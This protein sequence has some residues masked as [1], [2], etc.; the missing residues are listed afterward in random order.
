MK[1]K[2]KWYGSDIIDFLPLTID[3]IKITKIKELKRRV[4]IPRH[5]HITLKEDDVIKAY[6]RSKGIEQQV[7]RFEFL[8]KLMEESN[9]K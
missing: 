6:W 7:S 5:S 3:G 1:D 8:K 9:E 4:V 2:D